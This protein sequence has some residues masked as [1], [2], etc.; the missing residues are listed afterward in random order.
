MFKLNTITPN[1]VMSSL[2]LPAALEDVSS[3]GGEVPS[4][5]LEK[6][7]TVA[8]KGGSQKI[9]E[10]LRELPESLQRNEQI[11]SEVNCLFFIF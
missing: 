10:L 8:N 3:S 11:L 2:N 4:S 9:D 7:R 5:I 1:R 6:Q